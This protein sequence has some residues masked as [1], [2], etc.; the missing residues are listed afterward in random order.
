MGIYDYEEQY[1]GEFMRM[2]KN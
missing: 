2:L 1:V